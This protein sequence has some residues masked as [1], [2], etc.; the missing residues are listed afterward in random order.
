MNSNTVWVVEFDFGNGWCKVCGIGGILLAY[1]TRKSA[2]EW[3]RNFK[4]TKYGMLTNPKCRV[5]KYT[6]NKEV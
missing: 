1:S 6:Y 2:R 5:C 4:A 3:C